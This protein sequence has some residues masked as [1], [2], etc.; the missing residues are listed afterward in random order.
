MLLKRPDKP[1][2]TINTHS[3]EPLLT[4][5]FYAGAMTRNTY[6]HHVD[7]S[8]VIAI[9]SLNYVNYLCFNGIA[10]NNHDGIAWAFKNTPAVLKNRPQIKLP[11]SADFIIRP[12][13]APADII[14]MKPFERSQTVKNFFQCI[15]GDHVAWAIVCGHK[16][17][18]ID[19]AKKVIFPDIIQYP[20]SQPEPEVHW[21]CAV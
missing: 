16:A 5:D 2:L 12:Y 15:E 9:P 21:Y 1:W 10:D 13:E 8:T 17:F 19:I 7:H 3:A 6:G 20:V 14:S 18:C 11:R 4:K